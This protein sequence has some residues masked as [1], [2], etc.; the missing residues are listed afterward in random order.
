[1]DERAEQQIARLFR[2]GEVSSIDPVAHTAR[3][4]FQEDNGLVSYDLRVLERNTHD[5]CD[6]Q[7]PDIGE[8][9]L[10]I[11]LPC[12]SEDGFILGSWYAGEVTPPS[13]DPDERK[14]QFKDGTY[15]VYHREKHTLDIVDED[16][17]IHADRE[18]VTINTPKL[19]QVT[20]T[21]VE[22]N[23]SGNIKGTAG[24]NIELQAGGNVNINAGGSMSLT[25]AGALNLKGSPVNMN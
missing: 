10:C 3:V 25:A 5:N 14:V 13:T 11:F 2:V 6:H 22:V 8:D 19:V 12:G 4:A 7:M 16:T 18:K 1:M 17:S 21:D 23:A 20:T 15:I 24:G 9:V